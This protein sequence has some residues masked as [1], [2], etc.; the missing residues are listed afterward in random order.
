MR[1]VEEEDLESF[2]E[3]I[4]IQSLKEKNW[5]SSGPAVMQGYVMQTHM[6]NLELTS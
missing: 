1:R 4:A 2:R 3:N 6:E 5:V